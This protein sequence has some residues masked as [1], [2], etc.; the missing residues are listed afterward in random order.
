VAGESACHQQLI[1]GA[2]ERTARRR[3]L[4]FDLVGGAQSPVPAHAAVNAAPQSRHPGRLTVLGPGSP[5]GRG[6]A[7]CA[8]YFPGPRGRGPSR[9]REWAGVPSIWHS[10]GGAQSSVPD[11]PKDR[12]DAVPLGPA[13]AR[14]GTGRLSR[15]AGLARAPGSVFPCGP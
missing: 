9:P 4:P 13:E 14:K 12:G 10:P 11:V 5:A 7:L 2:F 3:S 8:R 15:V 6:A 1:I